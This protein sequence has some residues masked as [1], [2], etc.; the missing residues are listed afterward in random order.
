MAIQNVRVSGAHC[1][2]E[3]FYISQVKIRNEMEKSPLALAKTQVWR[4][5]WRIRRLHYFPASQSNIPFLCKVHFSAHASI[6]PIRLVKLRGTVD[7]QRPKRQHP[8][9]PRPVSTV[10]FIKVLDISDN[11]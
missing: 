5:S 3:N 7:F 11:W 6:C 8:E 2:Q 9:H 10:Y 4:R 1:Q